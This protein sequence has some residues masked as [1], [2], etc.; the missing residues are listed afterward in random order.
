MADAAPE[1]EVKQYDVIPAV[2]KGAHLE[3]MEEYKKMYQRSVDDPSGFWAEKARELLHWYRDFDIPQHGH[4]ADHSVSYFMHGTTNACT[5][6]ID[7]H[8][9]ERGD[10]AAVIWE[11]NEPGET[12]T[13]TY[14]ESLV[15]ICKI[16]NTLRA[17]GVK[18]GDTVTI[19]MPMVPELTFTMLA[20]ARIG[21]VH[22][23]VFAGFSAE[24]LRERVVEA[25]SRYVFVTD[26]GKRG[27]STLALKQIVDDAVK[28]LDFVQ[29]VFVF[30]RTGNEA[31]PFDAESGR[32]VWMDA[33]MA[34]HRPY[35]PPEWMDSE[36]PLFIL[37]TSGSTGRPKG[38]MHTTA[39]YMLYT[40]MT[41]K[42]VFDLREG[43][44]FACVADAGWITGHS[45][46]VYGPLLNGTTT[47]MFESTPLYP[48]HGRYWDLVQ[49]HKVNVF[50]T[51][52]TAIR[53][54]MRFSSDVVDKYDL[55]SLR[56]LGSVGEP[57]N[58]A[59]W[60]WYYNVIGKGKCYIVDTYW[61]TETGGHIGTGLPGC[62]PMR[63]GSCT[64][65]FFGIEFVLMDKDGKE[66]EG[67][68]VSGNLCI[69]N[70]WP[71]VM[72]SV[73]GDHERALTVY[74]K[75]YPGYYFTGDG[76]RRDADGF[77]WITGRVDDVLNVSG[78]R[79]GTA[80]VESALVAHAACSE[81][82][83]VG[84]PHEIKGEALCCYVT[85]TEAATET[86]EL[87]L[88]LRSAVRAGIGAFATPDY[89]V[90]APLPKTRS[91]KL[92]R[93]ILRKVV[94]G[95]T[96]Q[97]GDVS[98]LADPSVVEVIIAKVQAAKDAKKKK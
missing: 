73:Y 76:A 93:R 85:L 81:A 75:P 45:Y 87:L 27:A 72:R 46:I 91:G 37:Y 59:A 52:P 7:R 90:V 80:E 61:Q 24:A 2:A 3:G 83:C 6:C 5:N 10:Q 31:V 69:R 1:T 57:I 19:Y 60:E 47:L 53:A 48:D 82:A 66:I 25:K 41:T 68:D 54:L 17:R 26:E 33:E 35:C 50:Y 63:P 40:M 21:A 88:E 36:D 70:P 55:S 77:Y 9:P 44:V 78:H 96:D 49:R 11:G 12:K 8:I 30:K 71:G 23:V 4:F 65:P 32:D 64:M 89:I 84:F 95:E 34:S 38:I 79:I 56:V 20:C 92:M 43:D 67:N 39:G 51:A 16:A 74:M 22:S 58:P 15:E 86:P 29:H 97:I 14:K 18:K 94:A 42:Y 98:T 62:T 28:E 13:F